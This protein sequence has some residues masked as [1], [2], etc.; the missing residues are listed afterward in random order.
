MAAKK[1]TTEEW[2]A[3]IELAVA[4]LAEGLRRMQNWRPDV[5]GQDTLAAVIARAQARHAGKVTGVET[6]PAETLEQRKAAV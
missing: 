3:E 6:R 4:Q 1:Q 5:N 2:Q